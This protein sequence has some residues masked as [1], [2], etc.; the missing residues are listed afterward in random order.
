MCPYMLS[1]YLL[2]SLE[3]HLYTLSLSSIFTS[4]LL[5]NL[6]S[7]AV[8]LLKSALVRAHMSVL[9]INIGVWLLLLIIHIP[10]PHIL[11]F[12][13]SRILLTYN[14]F[15]LFYSFYIYFLFSEVSTFLLPEFLIVSPYLFLD[16]FIHAHV[17][18][19]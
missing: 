8:R 4:L 19:V 13:I 7:A 3:R 18:R 1:C 9:Y 6:I 11:A 14:I 12:F 5:K 17:S 16:Y 10:P 2:I 15:L